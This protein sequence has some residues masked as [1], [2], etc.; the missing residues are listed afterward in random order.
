M[1]GIK[2]L[3]QIQLFKETTP[4]TLGLATA[5]WRGLG[6][7]EDLREPYFPD[8]DIGLLV[9]TNRATTPFELAELE[10][11]EVAATYEQLPYLLTGGIK[12][13]NTGVVDGAGSGKVYTYPV[14]YQY[15]PNAFQTFSV[16]SG[17]NESVEFMP[18]AFVR[19]LTLSGKRKEP[20]MM[21]ATLGGRRT[22]P[23][24]YSAPLAFAA[25]TKTITDA[26]NGLAGFTTGMRIRV[27]GTVSN[28]G[29]Y[30][31]VNSSAGSLTVS[32][33]L[34]TEPAVS[35]TVQQYF[36]AA[37]LP[38]VEEILF[39]RTKFY[40]NPVGNPFGMTE[41]PCTL[42]EASIEIV[43]GIVEVFS[44]SGE[45]YFCAANLSAPEITMSLKF[46]HNAHAVQQKQLWRKNIP[47]LI[48][49]EASGSALATAGTH[50]TKKLIIDLPGVW[51]KISKV[52]EEDGNDFLEGDFLVAYDWLDAKYATITVVNELAS[53]P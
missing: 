19:S 35:C 49:L 38:A 37:P 28:D 51:E 33:T 53:L 6:I 43:T 20:W 25:D 23:N 1:A 21:S 4:G 27:S 11:E 41:I 9:A 26:A 24:S 13:V 18:Y 29:L 12:K 8:E 7:S 47:Q 46:E 50:A 30:T 17:D 31:V 42:W 40:A 48:R 52:G 14:S 5:K 10:L 3:R 44:A 45:L 39:N 34:V 22:E 36:T 2:K 15:P 16:E 32:E